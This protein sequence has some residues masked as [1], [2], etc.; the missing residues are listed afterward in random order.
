M[1]R[2]CF[3]RPHHALGCWTF[4][5]QR[6]AFSLPAVFIARLQRQPVSS[7]TSRAGESVPGKHARAHVHSDAGCAALPDSAVAERMA[8]LLHDDHENRR[9][10]RYALH[11][12]CGPPVVT[13]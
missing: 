13:D 9:P 11:L 3:D 7:E 2:I 12:A 5:P 8:D 1:S 10:D 4:L 6:F